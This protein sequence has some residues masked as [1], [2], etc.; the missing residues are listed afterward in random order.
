MDEETIPS[1]ER[2][3]WR[4][5][6]DLRPAV[7]VRVVAVAALLAVILVALTTSDLP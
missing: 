6:G 3:L 4:T 1:P 7:G 2:D 5:A